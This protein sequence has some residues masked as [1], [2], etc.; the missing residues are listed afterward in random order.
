[1]VLLKKIDSYTQDTSSMQPIPIPQ[2]SEEYYSNRQSIGED[3]VPRKNYYS[4]VNG[5]FIH[6]DYIDNKFYLL[7]LSSNSFKPY[8]ATIKS[9]L[10]KDTDP[11]LLYDSWGDKLGNLQ[12]LEVLST[13]NGVVFNFIF[14]SN[15]TNQEYNAQGFEADSNNEVLKISQIGSEDK[16]TIRYKYWKAGK[17]AQALTYFLDNKNA[18]LDDYQNP[19]REVTEEYKGKFQTSFCVK[20]TNGFKNLAVDS[21]DVAGVYDGIDDWFEGFY[22]GFK[23]VKDGKKLGIKANAFY[24]ENDLY[25]LTEIK[26][27]HVI[28][29]NKTYNQKMTIPI[30]GA[31]KGMIE[32]NGVLYVIQED[33]ITVVEGFSGIKQKCNVC[34]IYKNL[35][36]VFKVDDI[37]NGMDG[38]MIVKSGNKFYYA[39]NFEISGSIIM[40]KD[41]EEIFIDL[42]DTTDL[43]YPT[44][45]GSCTSEYATAYTQM[46][47]DPSASIGDI[48]LYFH[49][50]NLKQKK[51]ISYHYT[52]HFTEIDD[53]AYQI[54]NEDTNMGGEQAI[55]GYMD[56]GGNKIFNQNGV[57]I[58]VIRYEGLSANVLNNT[59][60]VL[61]E[62]E[63][64]F[65]A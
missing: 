60:L 44:V 25:Y 17:S 20:N 49:I 3:K 26:D 32:K 50:Y 31:F 56:Y 41:L 53:G 14:D 34:R 27:D 24:Y 15:G 23:G 8:D 38:G 63:I 51:T 2:E 61:D 30:A 18:E 4:F 37:V 48:K 40:F 6:K 21:M 54:S 42:T 5:R 19:I 22:Q 12:D 35:S 62:N 9:L 16:Y 11:C 52:C 57:D 10:R 29:K 55:I 13:N 39:A 43:S 28:L 46:D 64:T 33:N 47:D 36:Q 58:D 59:Y 65:T 7:D 1:M 45:L